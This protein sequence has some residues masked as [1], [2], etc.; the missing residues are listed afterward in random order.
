VAL[1]LIYMLFTRVLGWL[2]LRARSDAA[3]EIEILVV[4]H[5]L[6]VLIRGTPLPRM[7]WTDRA[8]IAALT[9]LLPPH[10][11]LGFLITPATQD[12]RDTLRAPPRVVGGWIETAAGVVGGPATAVP[13][14]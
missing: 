3:K 6:A 14:R 10:R 4:R 11:R 1:R 5:Q 8:L 13:G 12:R 2:V 9:R 7:N